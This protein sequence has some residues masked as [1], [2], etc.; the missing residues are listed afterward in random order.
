MKESFPQTWHVILD[1][2]QNFRAKD[3][4]WLEKAKT[5]VKQRESTHGRGY[6][7]CFMDRCQGIFKEKAAIPRHIGQTFNL[8][9]VIRNSNQIFCFAEVFMDW[10]IRRP[11]QG[12]ERTGKEVTIG[13]D[14][15]GEKVEVENS[16]GERITRLIGVLESLLQEGYS[17][18]DIAVLCLTEPLENNELERL[19]KFT[20]IVN[21][22]GNN[23]DKIVLSTVRE[24]GGLERPVV[25]VV[26]EPVGP[27]SRDV[28]YNRVRYC[29]YT[30]ARVKLIIVEKKS[31]A[32]KRKLLTVEEKP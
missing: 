9:K 8:T 23:E 32:Q 19:Q 16:K 2:V 31:K 27:K 3:G 30:R 11:Q 13:H 26:Q 12:Y 14:F 6:L 24:Y 22:E 25:I 21:A 15:E 20:S 1:E 10:R 18:G 28:V 17:E 29:A 5:L 4:K 7:W